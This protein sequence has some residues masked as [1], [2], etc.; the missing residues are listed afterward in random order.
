MARTMPLAG[1]GG[2]N[3][4][5]LHIFLQYSGFKP[6]YCNFETHKMKKI[7][8]ITSLVVYS[9]SAFCQSSPSTRDKIFFSKALL[10]SY[11]LQLSSGKS[12]H[13]PVSSGKILVFVFLSPECPISKNY[14]LKLS[15]IKKKYDK[16]VSF[17][18]IIP[19]TFDTKEVVAFQRDY[20]SSWSIFR[21]N[22][23]KLT[24]YLQGKVTPEV[25][26]I[27]NKNG[28]LIYKGA[29]DDWA[30]SPGKTRE[31]YLNLYLDN[32]LRDFLNNKKILTSYHT[33]VGCFIND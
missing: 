15:G 2:I 20:L 9:A 4:R 19:G 11:P 27:N 21:D 7:F 26:V 22:T 29:I 31:H 28:F 23:L 12:T 30:V 5:Y 8:F 3:H 24:H 13:L 32:A 25:I 33:P 16:Q 17:I 10:S 18:A 14:A 6:E 1:F